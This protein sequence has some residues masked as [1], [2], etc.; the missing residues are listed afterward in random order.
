VP[1]V[2]VSFSDTRLKRNGRELGKQQFWL[3][4]SLELGRRRQQQVRPRHPAPVPRPRPLLRAGWRCVSVRLRLFR[5]DACPSPWRF[6]TSWVP[7]VRPRCGRR[8]TPQPGKAALGGRLL[9][10]LR[11]LRGRGVDHSL[12]PLPGCLGLSR[13]GLSVCRCKGNW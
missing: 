2:W 11:L 1:L 3:R 10:C 7:W 13:V 12:P 8:G 9:P 5:G 6:C 4:W